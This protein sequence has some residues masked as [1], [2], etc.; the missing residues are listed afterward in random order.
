M[1]IKKDT[2]L[3]MAKAL[4]MPIADVEAAIANTEEVA[5]VLPEVTVLTA[6]EL[7]ARDTQTKAG[8]SNSAR[9][10]VIKEMKEKAGLD[11]DG[12]KSK[13][14]ERFITELQ[15]KALKDANIEESKKVTDR[16][17]TIT[18]LQQNLT[19]LQGEKAN[20][21]KLVADAQ[22]EG[23]ILTWTIDKKPD[24]LTNKEWVA[25]IKMNNEIINED[26][27]VV[28]KRD[29]KV[30][31][32]KTTLVPLA[33]K[34]ALTSYIDERK[35]GKPIAEPQKGPGRGAGNENKTVPGSIANMKQ[36]NEELKS[37]NINANGNEAK[38]LLKEVTTANPTFDYSTQ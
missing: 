24:N 30:V 37:R 19:T 20:S 22:L 28:V 4:K 3:A 7:T 10:I 34:D 8:A 17:A 16:D 18:Q 35:L 27:K 38:A 21:E 29:G 11:Y 2:I 1:P 5:M 9:E 36:F 33:P 31:A 12:E 13:D 23:D 32:D 6:A 14:P 26:G 15:K 25:I